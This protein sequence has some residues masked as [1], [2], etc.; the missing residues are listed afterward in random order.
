MWCGLIVR[1]SSTSAAAVAIGLLIGTV[2]ALAQD[3]LQAALNRVEQHR[4]AAA[5]CMRWPLKIEFYGGL[6]G[7][8]QVR[9]DSVS[10]R[11]CTIPPA[12]P[13]P[14]AYVLDG[15]VFCPDSN[16]AKWRTSPAAVGALQR[17]EIQE[18]VPV[19]DTLE[20]RTLAC[21]LRPAAA[22]VITTMAQHIDTLLLSGRLP[23]SLLRLPTSGVDEVFTCPRSEA[24]ALAIPRLLRNIH[25]YDI[26]SVEIRRVVQANH[27]SCRSAVD[28]IV[29]VYTWPFW[30]RTH[31][32]I[33]LRWSSG[34]WGVAAPETWR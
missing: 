25:R 29:V 7:D 26:H 4:I 6:S 1:S 13:A 21:P 24:R 16:P 8:T 18:I 34:S 10:G 12:P 9:R 22:L 23:D 28:A 33:R 30:R 27:P 32:E 19:K 31:S 20:L 14:I 17:P 5:E 15:R 11:E 2:P 3:S